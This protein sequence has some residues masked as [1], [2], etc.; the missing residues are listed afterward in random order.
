M[1]FIAHHSGSTGNLYQVISDAGNLVIDPGVPIS[2]IKKALD[3]KLSSVSAALVTHQHGDH[4]KGIK[5]IAR[6]GIDCYMSSQT[7]QAI[8]FDGHRLN[9]IEPRKQLQVAGFTIL[10]FETQHDCPG[11]VG[12]LVSDGNEKLLYITDSF[13][14]RYKF[15]GLNIIAVECN[16]SKETLWPN[17]D[18]FVKKR[19][20]RS[21][22]SLQRVKDFLKANDL[23][24]VREI[25][26]IHISRDNGDPDYFRSEI[27]RLTGKPVYVAQN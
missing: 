24:R 22:F 23:N 13:Y 26:L 3:F 11:S 7:A 4:I 10:P 12:F 1:Q 18:P 14:C 27:E 21:H 25:H 16:W 6:A 5:A 20:Y 19:I 2:K 8:K 17:I 9:I 15:K